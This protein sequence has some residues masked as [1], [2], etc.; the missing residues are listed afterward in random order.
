VFEASTVHRGRT[1]AVAQVT[2]RNAAGKI[3]TLATVTS[4]HGD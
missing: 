1:L 2:S 3:C 4:H